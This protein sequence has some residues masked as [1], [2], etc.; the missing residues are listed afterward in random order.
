MEAEVRGASTLWL[1]KHN[2]IYTYTFPNVLVRFFPAPG[3]EHVS[4]STIECVASGLEATIA[5]KRKGCFGLKG[6]GGQVTGQVKDM[7]TK[8]VMCEISGAWNR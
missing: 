2:E 8:V 3:C 6:S 5:F 4:T 1:D 7:N